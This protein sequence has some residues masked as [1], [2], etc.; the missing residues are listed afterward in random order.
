MKSPPAKWVAVMSWKPGTPS[1]SFDCVRFWNKTWIATSGTVVALSKDGK[2]WRL[3]DG[4]VWALAVHGD[5]IFGVHPARAAL[6]ASKDGEKWS[7]R[8]APGIEDSG[9]LSFGADVKGLLLVVTN[10]ENREELHRSSDGARTWTKLADVPRLSSLWTGASGIIVG[11][12][13]TFD[14]GTIVRS[15]DG[16]KTFEEVLAT[17]SE[18][19][20]VAGR[21]DL[22]IAAGKDGAWRSTDAGRSWSSL[23][24]PKASQKQQR[25][26]GVCVV[27]KRVVVSGS[28]A[29]LVR[30][31]DG[32]ETWTKD[33]PPAGE[34]FGGASADDQGNIIVTGAPKCL[35]HL[36][37]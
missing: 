10:A 23:T 6:W 27:G 36:H 11:V 1:P 5:E 29:R 8:T 12:G 30:S 26:G 24:L 21:E 14:S 25:V 20:V 33:T 28:G 22:L 4:Q 2:K 34:V 17:P 7:A 18:L 19:R 37:A 32:G 13:G 16:G 3:V 15:E 35:L 31:E 9:P